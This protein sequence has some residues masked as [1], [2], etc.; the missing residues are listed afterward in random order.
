MRKFLLAIIKF[1]TPVFCV[2]FAV[3]AWYVIVDPYRV[4]WEHDDYSKCPNP[5]YRSVKYLKQNDSTIYDSFIVGSSRSEYYPIDD[6]ETLIGDAKWLHLNAAADWTYGANQR[7]KYIYS[8]VPHVKNVIL[9]VDHDF[10]RNQKW[11]EGASYETPWQMTPEYDW[12]SFQYYMIKQFFSKNGL[13]FYLGIGDYYKYLF[14]VDKRNECHNLARE[15]AITCDP[16]FYY[17]HVYHNGAHNLYPRDTIQKMDTIIIGNDQ[18]EWL[19]E[20]HELFVNGGTNYKIIVSPL[21]DQ[22]KLNTDDKR[23][24]DS[25][26]G[27]ENV[28]DF[29]GINEYTN[30]TLNYYEDSHYRPCLARQLLN[31]VYSTNHDAK[32]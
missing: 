16:D 26:F 13:K 29:S 23:V 5:A 32:E 9:I 2:A 15:W 19:E 30:D 18:K 28:F 10:L 14:Y 3:V 20:I 11:Y 25:I 27:N 21:F 17:A 12:L 24:L 6:L 22:L 4:I 8:V 31:V 1:L 7:I